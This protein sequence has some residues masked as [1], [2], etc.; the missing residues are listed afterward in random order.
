[1][2]GKHVLVCTKHRGVF[3][4]LLHEENGSTLTLKDAQMCV[5]WDKSAHGVLG[6]SKKGP[7][8][9]CRISPAA[10]SLKLYGVIAVIECTE[11]AVKAWKGE[12]WS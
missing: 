4:G 11:D 2:T 12:P 10:M 5:A 6:L 9:R 1:M 3:F 7:N 8:K